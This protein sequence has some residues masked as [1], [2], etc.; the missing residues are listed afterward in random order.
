MAGGGIV[1]LVSGWVRAD[2]VGLLIGVSLALLGVIPP[3]QV[4]SGLGNPV[5]V[6]VLAVF[7]LTKGLE[8]AGLTDRLGERLAR[9]AAGSEAR[10]LT[11]VML[12]AAVLSL[13]MNTIAA[14]A[15]LLPPVVAIVRR[16]R[17]FSLRR[18]LMPLAFGTLLGGTATLLTTANLVTSATLEAHGYAPYGLLDFL[19]VGLPVTLTGLAFILLAGRRLLPAPE[20]RSDSPTP[21]DVL[22]ELERAYHL[23]RELHEVRV[24]EGSPLVGRPARRPRMARDVGLTPLGLVQEGE[25]VLIDRIA[26]DRPVRVGDVWLS[27]GEVSAEQLARYGLEELQNIEEYPLIHEGVV[28]AEVALNPRSRAVGQTPQALRL[29]GEYGVRVL[30]IWRNGHVIARRVY[31][32]PIQPGDALLVHGSPEDIRRMVESEDFVLLSQ[33]GMAQRMPPG[34]AV[35]AA[36][37]MVV[38]LAPAALG[39]LPLVLSALLGMLILL[40]G[41]VLSPDAAYRSVSWR[42][43]FLIGGMIPLAQA[44]QQ[45]GAAAYLSG[46]LLT[47]LGPQA[48]PWA[49][50][51]IFLL[52]TVGLAQVVSGQ[53]AAL[54]LSP[55]A[56]AAAEQYHLD[57][58]GLA[59]VVAVAASLAF[60]LPTAHPVNLLVMGPAGYRPRDYLRV[61]LPLT[62]VLIPVILLTLKIFWL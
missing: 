38:A 25:M 7:V 32:E 54:I 39:W 17:T 13:F 46:H 44:M 31:Q 37:A 3:T 52:V 62:L 5:V 45:T 28:L 43:V 48:P 51:G 59:M 35:L 2:L 41:G 8:V 26:P 9:L 23:S 15:V 6:V 22:R 50:A 42:V 16:E 33:V 20:P 49:V 47:W 11:V 53:A 57:P 18:V 12:A 55:L 40:L 19:P 60:L 27:S 21:Q 61:G 36:L 29:R 1:L 10:F 56:I 4:L 58:R 34:K 30:M 24:C 14:A